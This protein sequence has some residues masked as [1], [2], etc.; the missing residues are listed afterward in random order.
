MCVV[1]F[2]SRRRVMLM[3]KDT[4]GSH[5][6]PEKKFRS[7]NTFTHDKIISE[8]FLRNA[9]MLCAKF[10]W[11]LPS[12]SWE[13]NFVISSIYF[14]CFDF[15]FLLKRA[16]LLS[17]HYHLPRIFW[18]KVS[19]NWSSGSGEDYNSKRAGETMKMDRCTVGE[20]WSSTE[21]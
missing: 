14:R 16:C 19:W 20:Q 3:I 6:S 10:G 1:F 12:S 2:F 5:R 21:L 7:I 11:N 4:H 9:R 17:E 18:V 13:E 8:T 15:L